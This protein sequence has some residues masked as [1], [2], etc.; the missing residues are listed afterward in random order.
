ML[1]SIPLTGSS[2]VTL[3]KAYDALAKIDNLSLYGSTFDLTN[4]TNAFILA[5]RAAYNDALQ[6]ARDFASA[7]GVTIKKV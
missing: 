4:K 6:A 5:R 7:A 3:G 1:I 2:G